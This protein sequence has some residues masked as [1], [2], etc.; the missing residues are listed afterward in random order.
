MD[1]TEEEDLV[2]VENRGEESLAHLL[3]SFPPKE[4]GCREVQAYC[5]T[6]YIGS[7]E[8]QGGSGGA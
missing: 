7:G 5:V 1:I 2:E 8:S 3:K 6:G 4:G